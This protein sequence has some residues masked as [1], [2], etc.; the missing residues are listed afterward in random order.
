MEDA[1]MVAKSN[2]TILLLGESGT[3]KEVFARYIYDRS[4]RNNKPFIK[5]NCAAIPAN[6]I[7][8]EFFGHEKGAFTGAFARREGRFSL[9]DG[10]TLCL[11]EVGELPIEMQAKLLRVLQEGEFEPVGSQR[12]L[13]VDVRI[14]AATN[15]DLGQM[16]KHGTFREDLYYRLNVIP[17]TLPSLRERGDDV[18]SLANL[19]IRRF[20]REVGKDL[21]PIDDADARLLMQYSWPGNIRELEH[22]I[23]RAVVLSRHSRLDLHKFIPLSDVGIVQEI[24]DGLDGKILTMG[25]IQNIERQN[26]TKALNQCSWKVS[27]ANG[28]AQLL[29]IPPSTLHSKIKVLNITRS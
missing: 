2:S 14:I 10:G 3:G 22:V 25:E 5:V 9:A 16:V 13:K 4:E 18:I 28:A 23:E 15:R 8:S 29:G 21:L 24:A 27:G 6:L 12:T 7:E 1:A 20:A 11:D 17:I 19:F 26:I